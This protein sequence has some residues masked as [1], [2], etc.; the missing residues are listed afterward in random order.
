L[1]EE[2]AE[3]EVAARRERHSPLQEGKSKLENR[4]W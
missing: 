1:P 4:K 3:L 2:L